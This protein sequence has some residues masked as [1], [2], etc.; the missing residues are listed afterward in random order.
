MEH[1]LQGHV[2]VPLNDCGREQASIGNIGRT[3]HNYVN[4]EGNH[5][6][7]FRLFQ[8]RLLGVALKGA[9]Y[10]RAYSSDLGRAVETLQRITDELEM[11]YPTVFIIDQ[12]L[13]E[14]VNTNAHYTT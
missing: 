5:E 1:R 11:F 12:R 13:R 4:F 8:A 6:L 14:R 3:I 9:T 7:F 2:D 10:H